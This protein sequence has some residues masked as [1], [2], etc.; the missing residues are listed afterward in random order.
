MLCCI[1]LP[2]QQAALPAKAL[3]CLQ[4]CVYL[5]HLVL[6]ALC[7]CNVLCEAVQCLL[8]LLVPG[9]GRAFVSCLRE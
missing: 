7:A 4:Q 5:G 3:N 6:L 2:S 8:V 1:T 9:T